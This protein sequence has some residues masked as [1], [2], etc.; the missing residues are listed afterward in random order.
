MAQVTIGGAIDIPAYST[1]KTTT[2]SATTKS[3]GTGQLEGTHGKWTSSRFIIGAAE[4]L[5]G[6]LRA[7]M[8]YRLRMAEAGSVGVDD[9]YI[10]LTGGFGAL[11]IGQYALM[12]DNFNA[13]S[14]AIATN[15][16]GS[17]GSSSN[18]FVDGGMGTK[19]VDFDSAVPQTIRYVTPSFSGFTVTVDYLLD[20]RD[21]S[22]T[23]GEYSRTANGITLGYRVG[24]IELQ[25]NSSSGENTGSVSTAYGS[26]STPFAVP[27]GG[28]ATT[29]YTEATSKSK[30]SIQWIGANYN[31]GVARIKAAYG[32]R[33]DKGTDGL[34]DADITL[35]GLGVEFP[36][37]AATL[38]AHIYDG[39]NKA[40]G[41]AAN[42]VDLDGNQLGVKYN[43]SKRT[44][45]YGLIG[46]NKKKA[47]GSTSKWSESVIGLAHSF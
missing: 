26:S 42:K 4:D 7:S 16:A 23:T 18:D 37:G 41:V 46:E 45:V 15:T 6:G 29:A 21:A 24:A 11:R 34:K 25:V 43:L 39:E 33:E 17:T 28:S 5:G 12:A 19:V 35:T 38:Y 31:L 3:T 27:T 32:M 14:G 8:E 36:I 9:Y 44:Y 10:Q 47:V 22:S 40:D 20:E 2:G 1:Y 30:S 13:F